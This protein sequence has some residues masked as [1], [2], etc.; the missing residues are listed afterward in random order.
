MPPN[1]LE[2]L[3]VVPHPVLDVVHSHREVLAY[4]KNDGLEDQPWVAVE[5]D[6]AAYPASAPVLMTDTDRG[7]DEEAAR[8]L[9]ARLIS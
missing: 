7:F 2:I 4:L 8:Q 9:S 3:G 1:R 6:P 5:D